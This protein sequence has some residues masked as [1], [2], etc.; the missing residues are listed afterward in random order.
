MES[1][2]GAFSGVWAAL[3][4][5]V[6]LVSGV[7]ASRTES[8]FMGLGILILGAVFAE[9]VMDI[10]V[11]TNAIANPLFLGLMV[12]VYGAIGAV[13]TG[14]WRWP[15]YIKSHHYDIEDKFKAW[16]RN[17]DGSFDE[18]L[19]S[20]EYSRYTASKNK[21]RLASYVLMWPFHFTWEIIHKPFIWVYNSVY[22]FLGSTFDRIGKYYAKK[23]HNGR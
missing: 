12:L 17:H 19:D 13:Y 15:L 21:D 18:F 10:P 3:F 5:L 9:Y 16:H 7:L 23:L 22:V 1:F 8:M 6:F 4:V 14:L 20:Y 2:V 11:I